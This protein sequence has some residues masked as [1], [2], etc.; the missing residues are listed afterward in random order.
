MSTALHRIVSHF[1]N[2]LSLTEIKRLHVANIY[3]NLRFI[4]YLEKTYAVLLHSRKTGTALLSMRV[5]ILESYLG[6]P[7]EDSRAHDNWHEDA[8]TS[9]THISGAFHRQIIVESRQ[10]NGAMHPIHCQKNQY[11]E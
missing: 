11:V 1:Q 9:G 3:Q 5:L 4:Y 8:S 6:A 2:N 10:I 7:S